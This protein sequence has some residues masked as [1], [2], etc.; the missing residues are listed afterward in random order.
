ML[1]A[2][3]IDR[4]TR[5]AHAKLTPDRVGY[6]CHPDW[7]IDPARAPD[8]AL[9]R[10]QIATPDGLAATAAWYRAHGLL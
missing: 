7:T 4:L 10:A 2:A 3:R 5:G 8:A 6:F 9:W 1:A